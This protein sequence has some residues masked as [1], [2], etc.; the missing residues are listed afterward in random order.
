VPPGGTPGRRALCGFPRARTH[1]STTSPPVNSARFRRRSHGIWPPWWPRRHSRIGAPGL[2][3]YQR[4]S[5]QTPR[6]LRRSCQ[7][8]QHPRSR[9][10]P[11]SPP[12]RA[13]AT[14]RSKS[15]GSIFPLCALITIRLMPRISAICAGYI[16]TLPL[17]GRKSRVSSRRS[18]RSVAA[19]V[20]GGGRRVSLVSANPFMGSLSHRHAGCMSMTRTISRGSA[21]CSMPMVSGGLSGRQ[22][23]LER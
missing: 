1:S 9:A 12:R 3:R 17:T 2:S 5:Q 21:R 23:H 19:T 6:S 16:P 20:P 8:L 22:E 15:A 4:S 14:S 7:R 10:T 11:L 13:C 18:E